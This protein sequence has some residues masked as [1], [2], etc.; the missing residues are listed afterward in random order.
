[1]KSRR[2]AREA[3]LQA[4]YQCDTQGEWTKDAINLY[5]SRY[6]DFNNDEE[7]DCLPEDRG[8]SKDVNKFTEIEQDNFSFAKKL[9]IGVASNLEYIN[10]RL[11]QASSHWTV[12]RMSRVD[13]NILRLACFEMILMGDIPINVSINEAI[14]LAKAYGSDTSPTFVNGVLDHI[15]RSLGAIP[16]T[17]MDA[18][19]EEK[20]KIA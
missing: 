14:E 17:L 19:Y 13:R 1:M 8:D 18:I 2:K 10:S 3:A 9:I 7:D 11:S 15:A 6:D 5:F 12:Q 16:H 20:R 4:L